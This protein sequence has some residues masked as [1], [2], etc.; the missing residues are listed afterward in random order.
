M[1]EMIRQGYLPADTEGIPVGSPRAALDEVRA[2]NADFAC[3][4]LES[5]VDGPIAQTEDALMFGKPLIIVRE[6]LVPVEFSILV[7]PGTKPEDISTFSTHPAAEAQVRQWVA[8]NL[9]NAEFLPARSNAAAAQ[10]V[11]EGRADAAAAPPRAGQLQHLDTL[12]ASVAD[13]PGAFTRFVLVAPPGNIPPKTGDDRTGVTF[14]L[15]NKPSSL[16]DALSEFSVRG[17][18]MSRIS[19]RPTR[20][21]PG[22]YYFHVGLVGHIQDEAM[23]EALAGLYRCTQYLRFLGS[24]PRAELGET[25]GGVNGEGNHR[26][27]PPAGTFP[28]DYSESRSWVDKLQEQTEGAH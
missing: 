8:N 14:T 18:D 12:A 1:E 3:V 27:H 11:A 24:W 2:G 23:A 10:D 15:V 9:P 25:N 26:K 21:V 19:S 22:T 20:E 16:L 7:R 5:S 13:V 6:V 28:P 4:A 17:V